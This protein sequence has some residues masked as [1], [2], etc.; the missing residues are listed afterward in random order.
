MSWPL[1][2][3]RSRPVAA[4]PRRTPRVMWVLVVSAF[5]CGGLLSAA[6]FSIG[7][8]HEA[9]RGTSAESELAAAT[10]RTHFLSTQLAAARTALA[11]AQARSTSL[12][13][14]RRTLS[15]LDA[16]LLASLT[17]AKR[18]R[19]GVAAAA[20]PLGADLDR[21]TSE[22]HALGS[23]LTSTPAAQLDAGYVQTQV[24]YLA[25]SVDGFRSAVGALAAAVPAGR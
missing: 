6:G 19:A 20:A 3:Q 21:V 7:W 12:A 10:T 24:A 17:A 13:V 1:A 2:E 4:A 23:Y 14:S 15:R 8:R 18:S 16:S 9:Q 11:A 22:L 5:L 25:K